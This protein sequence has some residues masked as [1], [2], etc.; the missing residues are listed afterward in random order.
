MGLN[1]T[2]NDILEIFV[3]LGQSSVLGLLDVLLDLGLPG[4]V[5]GHLWRHQG[6][7]GHE[8]QVGVTNQLASQPQE[9]LLE[10][11]VRLGRDV[12]ILGN[13]SFSIELFRVISNIDNSYLKVLFAV[14]DNGLCLDLPVLDVHLVAGQH[15][16]DVLANPAQRSFRMENNVLTQASYLTR[17][18]CQLG[19]FL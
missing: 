4:G 13:N 15:N 12:V 7:H 17:S 8:L 3:V 16:G 10:V 14:E 5:H 6:R 9:G 18:L 11:V 19:T 1:V 2:I